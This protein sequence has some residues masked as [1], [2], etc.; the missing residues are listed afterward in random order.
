MSYE[1]STMRPVTPDNGIAQWVQACYLGADYN[2]A[3]Y[4]TTHIMDIPCLMPGTII[5]V[6]GVNS[7]GEWYQAAAEQF[8][9][10]LN[11]RLGRDDLDSGG[12]KGF[13]YE[14]RR[15]ETKNQNGKRYHRPI[16]PFY[17]GYKMQAD[18]LKL[19][20][21]IYHDERDMAWGGGAFQNGTNNLLQFWQDGFKRR[22][23]LLDLQKFNPEIDRFLGDAPPRTYYI[24]AAKRLAYLIDTIRKNHPNEPVN[25]VA[26]SQGTMIALCAMLYIKQRAPDTL[27]LNSSPYAFDTKMT[28]SFSAV[29]DS[30]D[31][32]SADARLKTFNYIADKIATAKADFGKVNEASAEC[33]HKNPEGCTSMFFHHDPEAKDWHPQIG[34][35]PVNAAGQKW[36]ES[37][38]S[39]RD[40]RG[41]IFINFNPHDRVVGV[42]PV[43][44][45]G[46]R[47]IPEELL[48]D[49]KPQVPD[50]VF[51]RVFARNS[52]Y[53]EKV[54]AIGEKQN[55]W[56]NYF[57]EDE[58]PGN[59]R[60][61][62][63]DQ[64][65]EDGILQTSDG[66]PVQTEQKDL[67]TFDDQPWYDFWNPPSSHVFLGIDLEATPKEN[68][69]AWINAPTVP[70]PAKLDDKF[71]LG[72]IQFDGREPGK[73][74]KG[75]QEDYD[76]Y[77]KHYPERTEITSPP[78]EPMIETP[79]DIEALK[80]KSANK[81]I[82]QTD[83]GRILTY[84]SDSGQ[85]PVRQVLSYDLTVGQGYAF[86]DERY[87]QYLL[88][89]ADWK[90]SDPFYQRGTLSTFQGYPPGLD[91][92]TVKNNKL[93][94]D[95]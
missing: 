18:D 77:W 27:I 21:S 13:D 11:E 39:S 7:E 62:S 74:N 66:T 78:D 85:N 17:W 6:H 14:A 41:K 87:W 22:L 8:C 20:P 79:I 56:F 35:G 15:F 54:P 51:Q 72:T 42:S 40:N 93:K 71:D 1:L 58:K 50:N 69:R 84:E 59:V 26:H 4:L 53:S 94:A 25:V 70:D 43:A 83:H 73:E 90:K 49:S 37:G 38:H 12:E 45:I 46:W 92:R 9:K 75:Q 31:V 67:R 36:Y 80:K 34:N 64:D 28:D 65:S 5:F 63:Y 89:L 16:I 95:D 44:G 23:G 52:G 2:D 48:N 91:T 33:K 81:Q 19:Y 47:G 82:P 10:G 3:R 55:Y 30:A 88:D 86:G 24:H 60:V 32:Q 61:A 68:E 57:Y 29:N 76:I